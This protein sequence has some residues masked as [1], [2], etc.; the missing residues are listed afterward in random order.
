MADL[1]LHPLCA[2]VA[3]LLGEWRGEGRGGYPGL[4]SF[5]YREEMRVWHTG[6]A[7]LALE[8][9]TWEV[10]ERGTSGRELHGESGYLR[11]AEGGR[12]ELVVAMAPGHAEVSSGSADGT[13]I[14]LASSGVLDAPSAAAVSAV[15]RTWWL[16]GD[17]LHY[18]LEMSALD[19]P[20]TWHLSAELR[21]V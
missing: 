18:D 1:P 16:D 17:V 13:R 20:M 12:L 14:S 3:F 15:T 4:R 9:R 7:Y 6:K 10:N 8:Q 19:Q 11:C 5:T 21:R 2:P